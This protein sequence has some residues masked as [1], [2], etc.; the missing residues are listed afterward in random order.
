M[1]R[2][3]YSPSR[4]TAVASPARIRTAG[5]RAGSGTVRRVAMLAGLLGAPAVL[6]FGAPAAEAAAGPSTT[7]Y[8]ATTGVNVSDCSAPT[9]PCKSIRYAIQQAESGPFDQGAVTILVRGGTYPENDAIDAS[10]LSSLTIRP[11]PGTGTV[12]V[13]GTGDGSVFFIGDGVVD[14]DDL[15]LSGGTPDGVYN[16][17]DATLTGDT[18]TRNTGSGYGGGVYNLGTAT[19]VG[20]TVTGN[21]AIQGGGGVFNDGTASLYADTITD[22][23]GNSGGG[24]ANTGK[25]TVSGGTIS[26]NTALIVGGGLSNRATLALNGVA[27]RDNTTKGFGGGLANNGS[28][29][30]DGSTVTGNSATRGGGIGSVATTRLI[31][32]FVEGNTPDDC[33]PGSLCN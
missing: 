33:D 6:G 11:A 22:N 31:S 32:T 28:A 30:L 24:I 16:R 3:S 20:D 23:S 29:T 2:W 1:M 7:L 12:T 26:G 15:T 13:D 8:V 9:V 4:P 10:R 17:G 25:M 14:L 21:S 18:I 5:T 27:I 19:L